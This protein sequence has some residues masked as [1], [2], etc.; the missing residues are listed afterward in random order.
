MGAAEKVLHN[1]HVFSLFLKPH[2]LYQRGHQPRGVHS[3]SSSGP[4][5]SGGISLEIKEKSG[6]VGWGRICSS[7]EAEPGDSLKREEAG[8]L[9]FLLSLYPLAQ[10]PKAFSSQKTGFTDLCGWALLSAE[11]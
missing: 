11:G 8:W 7:P 4:E 9:C 10:R 5:Q 6:M 2:Q 3:V 1:P